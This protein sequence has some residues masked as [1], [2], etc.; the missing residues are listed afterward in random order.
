MVFDARDLD[1]MLHDAFE[2]YIG[3]DVALSVSSPSKKEDR[4][5]QIGGWIEN[6]FPHGVLVGRM[7]EFGLPVYEFFAYVDFYT[8]HARVVS[9]PVK[10]AVLE[11]LPEI[12]TAVGL[13]LRNSQIPLQKS[14]LVA[15]GD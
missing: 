12:R 15:S 5:K 7:T 1:R 10:T 11:V 14:I 6:V 4:A 9:G 8:L 3:E 2:S 13:V